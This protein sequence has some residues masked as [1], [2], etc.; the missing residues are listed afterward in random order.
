MPNL[1]RTLDG[2]ERKPSEPLP[3][4]LA[5]GSLVEGIWAGS[6]M[7]EKLD[8][9]LRK[10]GNELVQSE[11][12]AAIAVKADDNGEIIWSDAPAG[13]RLLFVL[14]AAPPGKNYRLAKMVTTAA[15]PA[16]IACFRH[17]R[18]S[19]FG[20]LQPDGTIQRISPLTPR[21]PVGPAQGELF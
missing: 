5:D 15:N 20:A 19:L 12:I 9:W 3:L 18:F 13:A 10:A 4:Q 6:A 14:E 16:Q 11:V 21:P 1:Y 8:W 7:E 17:H 2:H